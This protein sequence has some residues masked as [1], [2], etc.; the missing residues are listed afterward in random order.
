MRLIIKSS[1]DRE[2]LKLDGPRAGDNYLNAAPQREDF[3][4]SSIALD[5]S[6]S[7]VDFAPSEDR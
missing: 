5:R 1:K 6:T 3:E 7:K 2:A 4:D